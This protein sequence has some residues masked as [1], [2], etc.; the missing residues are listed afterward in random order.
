[1]LWGGKGD[2]V[3]MPTGTRAFWSS[4]RP[5]S[6]L[7]EAVVAI[8][9]IAI[10]VPQVGA[11]GHTATTHGAF[12]LMTVLGALAGTQAFIAARAPGRAPMVICPT[13]CFTFAVQLC[14]G[15][16]PAIAAQSV[17]V[18]VVAL[19]LR[20]GWRDAV[21]S[22]GQIALAFGAASIVLY[23]GDPD[24]FHRDGPNNIVVDAVSVIGAVAV[25]VLVYTAL[26]AVNAWTHGRW[27]RSRAG[28][29]ATANQLLFNG[30]L[31]LLSPVLAVTAHIDLGFLPLIFIPLYAV[32][33]MAKLSAERDLAA[34]L[35]P[36]TGLA[37]RTGLR[38]GFDEV[39]AL[40]AASDD[41]PSRRTTLLMLDL[42]RFKQVNDAL[43]HDVGDQLL[44]AV[45]RRL[46][47][48]RPDTGTVAR[49]GGDEFA[50]LAATRDAREAHELAERVVH[51]LN[52]PVTLDGLRVDIT[53]SVGIA[54]RTDDHTDFTSLMRYADVAMYDAKQRGDAIAAYQPRH[55]TNS[56]QRLQLLT[57]FRHA[58]ETGDREQVCLHY[59][60][61]VALDGGTVEGVEALLRWRHPRYGPIDTQELLSVAEHSSVMHLLTLRVI[62]DVV[63]QVAAWRTE[64]IHLRA[65][66]NVS[67]R[68]LYSDDIVAHLGA[69]LTRHAVPPAQIQIEITES[70]LLA[71][72]GRAIGTVNRVCALG[73]SVAL[74]DFGT[75]YSSLQHLRKLPIA[76]IKID[77]SFVA[78][79]ADN[80]DDAAIVR[81]TIDLARSLGIRT[82]AEGV[83]TEYTRALLAESGC[84]LAQGWLTAYPMPAEELTGW[85]AANRATSNGAGGG[86]PSHAEAAA[87][88]AEHMPMPA[89]AVPG[90]PDAAGGA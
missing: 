26:D 76:E 74:D 49:L 50:I 13:I 45:A 16:G 62:D 87:V 82:V 18:V 73:V 63:A 79:M 59:Q 31:L 83:E 51:A 12:W 30:S 15:L 57:D 11:V 33:R 72:P 25:W 43:G 77:R 90:R 65:S 39:T 7:V 55:D 86:T 52:Q 5:T 40:C 44:I 88:R 8:A 41:R 69:T 9:A 23:L 85:L 27:M 53:A 56:P 19:R 54:V 61:Q 89:E 20:A 46:A 29:N 17:A 60:P 47:A 42:D 6:I 1:M 84:G 36:L 21:F 80:R 68:D 67:S 71:D 70:A 28:A 2:A 58:L 14:W 75:G 48:L 38:H 24:P 32:H 4:R 66:I 35:D 34:R 78:G 64:G 10:F 81:S 3:S 22:W 37:N